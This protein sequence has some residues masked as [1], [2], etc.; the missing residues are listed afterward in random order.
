MEF[1]IRSMQVD[2]I[3]QVQHVAKTSWHNTYEGII[4]HMIQER[5]LDVAYS[6]EMMKK[7]VENSFIFVVE[8]AG[9]VVGYADFSPVKKGGEVELAAIYLL[10]EHQGKGMG[11]ALLQTGI[12]HSK[13][14]K[15]LFINVEEEN[16]SGTAFYRAK[17]F[18]VVSQFD[19]DFDGHVLKTVRM[20]LKEGGL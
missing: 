1:T 15:E 3:P 6:D 20:V 18:D 4:P 14:W 2:D 9:R 19:D 7:R 10:P 17:G 12:H 11:T 8:V 5:F 13:G 16:E